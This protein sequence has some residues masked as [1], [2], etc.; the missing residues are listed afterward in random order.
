[1]FQPDTGDDVRRDAMI[2]ITPR[3]AK[4]LFNYKGH[5]WINLQTNNELEWWIEKAIQCRCH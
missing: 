5:P 3:A 1:M 4:A 2:K